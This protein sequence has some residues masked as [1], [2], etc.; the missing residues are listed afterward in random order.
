VFIDGRYIS[1]ERGTTPTARR[2]TAGTTSGG[3]TKL[4]GAAVRLRPQ[5]FGELQHVDGISPAWPV[6]YDDF[7]PYY[8]KADA[9]RVAAT[10]AK[11]PPRVRGAQYPWPAVSHEPHPAALRRPRAPATSRSTP[12]GIQFDEADRAK[13]T[14]IGARGATATCARS[15]G[16][17]GDDGGT[18]H[19]GRPNV[20]L[21]VDVPVT[22]L[23]TRLG[24]R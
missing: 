12:C 9:L 11:I 2:S 8:T 1:D 13:S 23:E 21:L 22:A 3:A 15:Q 17:C 20:T 4:Y 19:P 14:R 6:S 5:D 24:Q 10:T 16:G 18:S 7:E